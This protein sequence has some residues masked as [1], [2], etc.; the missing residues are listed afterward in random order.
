MQVIALYLLLMLGALS[1]IGGAFQKFPENR[2]VA[3]FASLLF[4]SIAGL[5]AF[6]LYIA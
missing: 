1:F 4:C 2:S 6:S 3:W 5:Q